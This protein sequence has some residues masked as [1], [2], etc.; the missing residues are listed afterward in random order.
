MESVAM[1]DSQSHL[2]D[3]LGRALI[4]VIE[5]NP[6][7]QQLERFFLEEAGYQVEFA[8]DG[9]AA[10]ARVR[11]LRPKIIVSEILVPLLDGLS[12][13]RA[14]KADPET[15]SIV[16]LLFSH[17]QAEDRAHD[18]G[19]DGFLIKPFDEE[20]LVETVA[21]I[22]EIRRNTKGEEAWPSNA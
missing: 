6:I 4:L 16:V 11:E 9:L 3:S 2:A 5:R 21:R 15:R 14:I 18:A 13:C 10:L 22:L 12:L 8:T 1:T 17:L 20:M 7:V 19:A